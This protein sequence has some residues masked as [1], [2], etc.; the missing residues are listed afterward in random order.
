MIFSRS[1]DTQTASAMIS[2][3]PSLR[4][5]STCTSIPTSATFQNAHQ[6]YVSQLIISST[7]DIAA[8]TQPITLNRAPAL[9]IPSTCR[10]LTNFIDLLEYKVSASREFFQGFSF[11]AYDEDFAEC[12]C[13]NIDRIAKRHRLTIGGF[14]V[15]GYSRTSSKPIPYSSSVA[16]IFSIAGLITMVVWTPHAE[17]SPYAVPT[18]SLKLNPARMIMAS[19]GKGHPDSKN[20]NSVL[21]ISSEETPPVIPDER[22]ILHGLLDWAYEILPGIL[23]RVLRLPQ[24]RVGTIDCPNFRIIPK[25][26][27][28]PT[29]IVIP[30]KPFGKRL[31]ASLRTLLEETPGVKVSKEGILR[32][33][34][35]GNYEIKVYIKECPHLRGSPLL[36]RIEP[37]VKLTGNSQ[38]VKDF[39]H[40]DLDRFMAI[41]ADVRHRTKALVREAWDLMAGVQ[42]NGE[43]RELL[44]QLPHLLGK[45]LEKMVYSGSFPKGAGR[46]RERIHGLLLESG[47]LLPKIQ[48]SAGLR[49]H[50]HARSYLAKRINSVKS[51][52][53]QQSMAEMRCLDSVRHL[54]RPDP[55]SSSYAYTPTGNGKS[56]VPSHSCGVTV[57]LRGMS[58]NLP[59]IGCKPDDSPVSKATRL[60]A[61][62][63]VPSGTES[64]TMC[65]AQCHPA[66][67]YPEVPLQA[68]SSSPEVLNRTCLEVIRPGHGDGHAVGQ[69]MSGGG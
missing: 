12:S 34:I 11:D 23:R 43:Q 13:I 56:L 65:G 39:K 48:R 5:N 49:L 68:A 61:P 36:L 69:P 32:A 57:N 37:K 10:S 19:Q 21:M 3:D 35:S 50:Y 7:Q 58:P 22:E 63:L 26:I 25:S 31:M 54:P 45:D 47:L 18:V 51:L 38:A 67:D 59:H 42:L 53:E 16:R 17:E 41:M 1:E 44:D 6:P 2:P 20:G 40:G 24:H 14:P 29:D 46:Q 62:L 55:H 27:E 4:A 8:F 64:R 60:S 15:T 30:S 66:E 28:L 33:I 9:S 52:P